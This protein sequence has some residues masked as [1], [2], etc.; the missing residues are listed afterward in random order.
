MTVA[1][2]PFSAF[3]DCQVP[4]PFRH[5]LREG[6]FFKHSAGSRDPRSNPD[7]QRA[8]C[9]VLE[10]L[11]EGRPVHFG[12]YPSGVCRRVLLLAAGAED[13]G[14]VAV[15]TRF[16]NGAEANLLAQK[17]LQLVFFPAPKHAA[18]YYEAGAFSAAMGPADTL[19]G[20]VGMLRLLYDPRINLAQLT[21][22]QSSVNLQRPQV[23]ALLKTPEHNLP[24]CYFRWRHYLLDHAFSFVRGLGISRLAV[25]PVEERD[26]PLTCRMRNADLVIERALKNGFSLSE[27]RSVLIDCKGK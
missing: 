17:S 15:A 20:S 23:S 21:D 4:S 9:R 13:K 7:T 27:D 12:D 26:F 10:S 1:S 16:S 2:S 11:S 25:G 5:D 24:G 6:I 3:V 22:L 14:S 19:P 8:L 18:A